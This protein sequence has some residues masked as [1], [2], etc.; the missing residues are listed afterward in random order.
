MKK[1]H[2]VMSGYG[3]S[4]GNTEDDSYILCDPA[5]QYGEAK[6]TYDWK[7]VTC[8]RCLFYIR[9]MKENPQPY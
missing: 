8:K 9:K 7:N 5:G 3:P 1:V 6:D 4:E 2:A